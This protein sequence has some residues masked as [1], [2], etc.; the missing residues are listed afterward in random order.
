M[1]FLFLYLEVHF[2]VTELCAR[3]FMFYVSDVA[4]KHGF[5]VR[6]NLSFVHFVTP[7]GSLWHVQHLKRGGRYS[8]VG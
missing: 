5:F 1:F 7:F 8:C 3:V 4:S 6:F 2:K